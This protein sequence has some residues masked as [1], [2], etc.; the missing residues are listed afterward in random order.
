M[1]TEIQVRQ[2][3]HKGAKLI[4]RVI[5]DWTSDGSGDATEE[6]ENLHGFL[7]KMTTDPDA[8]AAPTAAYDVTLVDED[9][10]DAL[11]GAGADRS[12]SDVESVY[13]VGSGAQ[14][15]VL[16]CGAHTLTIANA[17]A[18]KAG[19]VVLYIVDSL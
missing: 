5:V 17:G 12:A 3:S 11:A 18:S 2:G 13:P 10:A 9:G 16:L 1:A 8:A 19:R 6:L 4:Q 14:T 15:P 7:V